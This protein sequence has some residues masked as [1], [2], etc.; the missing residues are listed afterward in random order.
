MEIGHKL[1]NRRGDGRETL[2]D[3]ILISLSGTIWFVAKLFAG[4]VT[5]SPIHKSQ[6]FLMGVIMIISQYLPLNREAGW[7][8]RMSH[9]YSIHSHT[10]TWSEHKNGICIKINI[11]VFKSNR[12][13]SVD[14]YIASP[15]NY[16]STRLKNQQTAW[17]YLRFWRLIN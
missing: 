10:A 4:C 16:C 8:D 3:N 15:S 14:N 9:T 5:K 1:I 12:V 11:L 6:I 7:S 17:L 13:C 2:D